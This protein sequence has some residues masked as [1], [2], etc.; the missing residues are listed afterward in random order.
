[1]LH[2]K[3]LT[4]RKKCVNDISCL[5]TMTCDSTKKI[6]QKR[7]I[8]QYITHSSLQPTE[9]GRAPLIHFQKIFFKRVFMYQNQ[10]KRSNFMHESLYR[11]VKVSKRARKCWIKPQIWFKMCFLKKKI[12]CLILNISIALILWK[13]IGVWFRTYF[14]PLV[15]FDVSF[16]N[17]LSTAINNFIKPKVDFFS[18]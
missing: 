9:A 17:L 15:E 10:S 3:T 7:K 4:L 11:V 2:K 8:S 16:L 6:A 12:S 14:F 1:M 5:T 13:R 18:K